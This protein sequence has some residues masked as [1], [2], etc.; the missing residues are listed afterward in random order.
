[1]RPPALANRCIVTLNFSVS[2]PSLQLVDVSVYV[3][4]MGVLPALMPYG[5]KCMAHGAP[6]HGSEAASPPIRLALGENFGLCLCADVRQIER[7]APSFDFFY[8]YH[9]R[10]QS[11]QEA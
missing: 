4:L 3:A 10:W 1:M 7:S 5:R 8:A 11:C 2:M 6:P 9:H